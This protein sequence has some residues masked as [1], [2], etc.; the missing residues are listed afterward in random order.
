MHCGLSHWGGRLPHCAVLCC[1]RN[2]SGAGIIRVN[3]VGAIEK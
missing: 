2:D 3:V 1:G